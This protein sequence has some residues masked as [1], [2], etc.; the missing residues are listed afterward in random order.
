MS[1]HK[2]CNFFPPYIPLPS[3]HETLPLS[4][5][6]SLFLRPALRKLLLL[7]PPSSAHRLR[8]YSFLKRNDK[9]SDRNKRAVSNLFTEA[10][11]APR[12]AVGVSR[13][14]CN[15]RS[16][17]WRAEWNTSGGE[18]RKREKKCHCLQCR[19]NVHRPKVQ[20]ICTHVKRTVYWS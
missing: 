8:S 9:R 19:L 18:G 10:C 15:S 7:P 14:R 16:C 20:S 3:F 17:L 5:H 4:S 13:R 12:L 11:W 6:F 2:A 1:A